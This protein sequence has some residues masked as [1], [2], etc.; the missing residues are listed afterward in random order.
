MRA[1]V[2]RGKKVRVRVLGV[3]GHAS[4]RNGTCVCVCVCV[5]VCARMV[6]REC[7]HQHCTDA[8]HRCTRNQ[9][10]PFPAFAHQTKCVVRTRL[11]GQPDVHHLSQGHVFCRWHSHLPQAR[12]LHALVSCAGCLMLAELPTVD[13]SKRLGVPNQARVREVVCAQQAEIC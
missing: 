7:S 4:L 9:Q 12:I 6:T 10:T 1:F 3:C 13:H 11:C 8:P 2:W 5:C